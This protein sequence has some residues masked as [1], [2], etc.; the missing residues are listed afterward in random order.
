MMHPGD[1]FSNVIAGARLYRQRCRKTLGRGLVG[2]GGYLG[3]PGTATDF[4]SGDHSCNSVTGSK[5]GLVI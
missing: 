2:E 3:W 1:N 5:A 4:R